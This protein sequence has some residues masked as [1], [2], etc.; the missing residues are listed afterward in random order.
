[1]TLLWWLVPLLA[2]L[3]VAGVTLANRRV[4][5][6]WRRTGRIRRTARVLAMFFALAAIAF[7]VAGLVALGGQS[8]RGVRELVVGAGAALIAA[9]YYWRSR[10]E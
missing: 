5:S 3:L 2:M 4:W 10:V 6:Q 7:V 8:Q 1:M 9:F